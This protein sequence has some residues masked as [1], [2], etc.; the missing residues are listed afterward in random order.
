MLKPC[1]FVKNEVVCLMHVDDCL[2]FGRDQATMQA[3]INKIKKAVSD[4][5]IQDDICTFLGAGVKLNPNARSIELLQMGLIEKILQ[6]TNLQDCNS[7]KL[8]WLK[9]SLGGGDPSE[10]SHD[11]EWG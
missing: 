3:L 11:E 10:S 5:T 2:F 8:P 6:L 7:N 9:E 4:L 1:L